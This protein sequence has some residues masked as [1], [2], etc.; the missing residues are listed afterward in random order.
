MNGNYEIIEDSLGLYELSRQNASSIVEAILDTLTRC[1]LDVHNC[2]GQ[3]YD[4]ASN[5]SG[6]YSGVSALI[7]N[8]QPKAMYV[9]CN[10]H[11][12]DLAVHDVTDQCTTI[13]H[14]M[15]FVKEIVDFIQRSPKRL[16]ILKE[17]SN[18]LSMFHSN[19][20][21][22]CPTRWTMRAE[23]YTSLLKNYELGNT[24]LCT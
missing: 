23:S 9:H 8:H 10:A 12:L 16:S 24:P 7:L 14:C 20:K 19:L 13:S 18:H 21:P 4:G 11:C 2:R 6:G 22:L 3:S 1:G 5:M 15:S 17:V